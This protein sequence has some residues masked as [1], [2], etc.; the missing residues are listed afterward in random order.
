MNIHGHFIRPGTSLSEHVAR[1]IQRDFRPP[2]RKSENVTRRRSG[3]M[4]RFVVATAGGVKRVSIATGKR[5]L[6]LGRTVRRLTS[7]KKR[8][9]SISPQ[10]TFFP[11]IPNPQI[12]NTSRRSTAADNTHGGPQPLPS[13]HVFPFLTPANS[14]HDIL[15]AK[16]SIHTPSIRKLPPAPARARFIYDPAIRVYT[17]PRPRSSYFRFSA[18]YGR[19]NSSH[20]LGAM[21]WRD[22]ARM[23]RFSIISDASS[24]VLGLTPIYEATGEMPSPLLRR[25]RIT[26]NTEANFDSGELSSVQN[27]SRDMGESASE[28]QMSSSRS[29][30]RGPQ[31]YRTTSNSTSPA[32]QE[33]TME[34]SVPSESFSSK[35]HEPPASYSRYY[36]ESLIAEIPSNRSRDIQPLRRSQT[37]PVEPYSLHTIYPTDGSSS[38][39]SSLRASSVPVDPPVQFAAFTRAGHHSSR[40]GTAE[41]DPHYL[42]RAAASHRYTQSQARA[43]EI[44]EA[45]LDAPSRRAGR[46]NQLH[47][48]A[49]GTDNVRCT[50]HPEGA[51]GEGGKRRRRRRPGL[52][53]DTTVSQRTYRSSWGLE[54][55][56]PLLRNESAPLPAIRSG[57]SEERHVSI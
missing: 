2:T 11:G 26:R 23:S 55:H 35:D 12:S 34:G 16:L 45:D 29:G 13:C 40:R 19:P 48:S 10:G 15:T 38:V 8:R 4:K 49:E 50:R 25:P 36:A 7:P 47:Y 28:R 27:G 33:R 14:I 5:G 37:V 17:H 21:G 51:P 46:V 3:R 24:D 43:N 32:Q 53:I 6:K 44:L 39:S 30:S 57:C 20:D 31:R 1:E 56:A 9:I 42:Q 52:S 54:W 18:M 41:M 22:S